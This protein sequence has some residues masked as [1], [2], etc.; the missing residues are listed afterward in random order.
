M[1]TKTTTTDDNLATISELQ[2]DMLRQDVRIARS[3]LASLEPEQRQQ[4]RAWLDDLRT[5]QM[6]EF[7][8]A[9]HDP[10]DLRCRLAREGFDVP[11]DREITETEAHD[12]AVWLDLVA[13]AEQT[14][15]V[16]PEWPDWLDPFEDLP[17]EDRQLN[18]EPDRNRTIGELQAEL[19]QHRITVPHGVLAEQDSERL[20]QVRQWLC[21]ATAEPPVWLAEY[22]DDNP[23]VPAQHR[24]N[25]PVEFGNLSIGDA[26][27]RLSLRI[28]RDELDLDDA[29]ETLC[30][31]R[32]TATI[33]VGDGHPRLFDSDPVPKIMS[34]FDTR[35][36]GI[37]SK[38]YSTGLTCALQEVDVRELA[39]FAKQRGVIRIADV[40]AIPEEEKPRRSSHP[41][42]E[43][44]LDRPHGQPVLEAV[45]RAKQQQKPDDPAGREPLS[46]L[47]KANLK[48][49]IGTSHFDRYEKSSQEGIGLTKRQVETLGAAVEGGTIADLEQ[50]IARDAWWHRSIKGFGEKRITQVID[51][52]TAYRV[53]FP[54]PS[55]PDDEPEP[56]AEAEPADDDP[57]NDSDQLSDVLLLV[58]LDVPDDQQ[59]GWSPEERQSAYR[60]CDAVH[61]G[62]TGETVE[63]PAVPGCLAAHVPDAM[64]ADPVSAGKGE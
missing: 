49:K 52:L 50:L 57:W 45:A 46:V 64:A 63:I 60:W 21:D 25:I 36:V 42:V 7:L 13:A 10:E 39:R 31:R 35:K 19:L 56:A 48:R 38:H 16:A 41:D 3:E 32:L 14:G 55:E 17:P 54:A 1:T 20:Q 34:A 62:S 59:D 40:S 29:V 58:G 9:Y 53:A 18:P 5:G 6:P 61:R 23:L 12:A 43:A 28:E 27:A 8:I 2:R 47:I 4:I 22:R 44:G 11:M 33:E 24:R 26:S 30:E 51:S 37:G 15:D